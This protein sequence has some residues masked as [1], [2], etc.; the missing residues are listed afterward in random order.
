[1]TPAQRKGEHPASSS[2][3]PSPRGSLRIRGRTWNRSAWHA[4]NGDKGVATERHTRR[5]IW[6]RP[7]QSPGSLGT[8]CPPTPSIFSDNLACRRPTARSQQRFKERP[9]PG[10]RGLVHPQ[11]TSGI[12]LLHRAQM[13]RRASVGGGV[14]WFGIPVRLRAGNCSCPEE[15]S[16][17]QIFV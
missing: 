15:L 16:P 10:T 8:A 9:L 2:A 4:H 12:G 1:M 17:Q 5:R 7:P 3:S 13:A 6:R 14:T 11:T